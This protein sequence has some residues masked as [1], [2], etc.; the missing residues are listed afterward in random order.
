MLRT[1]EACEHTEAL[2]ID[3][4]NMA[5]YVVGELAMGS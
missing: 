5:A 2:M 3:W 4:E 1:T